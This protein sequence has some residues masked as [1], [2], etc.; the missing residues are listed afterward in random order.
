MT[1]IADNT[2]PMKNSMKRKIRAWE[3]AC[4]LSKVIQEHNLLK[5]EGVSSALALLTKQPGT[6][7]R[8]TDLLGNELP[9]KTM[10]LFGYNSIGKV[11]VGLTVNFKE[12]WTMHE[13]CYSSK[14]V[15][16]WLKGWERKGYK[17]KLENGN[18]TLIATN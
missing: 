12:R 3:A 8:L 1:Q 14:E 5:V 10:F 16:R 6:G 13:G 2:T 9:S 15:G 18:I 11:P 17:F 4:L 7:R